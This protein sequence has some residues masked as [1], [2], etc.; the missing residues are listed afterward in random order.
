MCRIV[1]FPI[2]SPAVHLAQEERSGRLSRRWARCV[3]GLVAHHLP[4]TT[5][6]TPAQSLSHLEPKKSGGPAPRWW[7]SDARGLC[8]RVRRSDHCWRATW[9][10]SVG[11]F[12]RSARGCKVQSAKCISHHSSQCMESSCIVVWR[13]MFAYLSILLLVC[14]VNS[15][16]V[17]FIDISALFLYIWYWDW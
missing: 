8:R 13:V 16:F 5:N 1:G 4:V 17:S 9:C 2:S 12:W 3:G 11:C 15:I 6:G 7:V 10:D 14:Q